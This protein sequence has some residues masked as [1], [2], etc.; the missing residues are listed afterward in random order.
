MSAREKARAR[1]RARDQPKRRDDGQKDTLDSAHKQAKH[2]T[3]HSPQ[4][5][6]FCTCIPFN[7]LA[8]PWNCLDLSCV[9]DATNEQTEQTNNTIEDVLGRRAVDLCHPGF[10]EAQGA[11][12]RY[13]FE[14]VRATVDVAASSTSVHLL[15][16]S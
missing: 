15:H 2:M 13:V 4:Q 16:D 1:E 5:Y 6:A 12:H 7:T 9:L 11:L 10:D 8:N 14:C 3:H